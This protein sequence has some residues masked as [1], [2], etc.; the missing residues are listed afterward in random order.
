L[1]GELVEMSKEFVD[2]LVSVL[3]PL[4]RGE[5]IGVERSDAA[6]PLADVTPQLG[7]LIA[8]SAVG[9]D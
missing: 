2:S 7:V 4:I 1:I 6:L 9:F 5:Q 8:K 3:S